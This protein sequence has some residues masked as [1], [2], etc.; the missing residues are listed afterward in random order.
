M[1]LTSLTK[2]KRLLINAL[3]IF[4]GILSVLRYFKTGDM[5]LLWTGLI[6]GVAHLVVFLWTFFKSEK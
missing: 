1:K 5:F 3:W 2:N 6:I 4:Y